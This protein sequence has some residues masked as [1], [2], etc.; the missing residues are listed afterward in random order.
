MDDA[1]LSLQQQKVANSEVAKKNVSVVGDEAAN[2][3]VIHEQR[4]AARYQPPP[5]RRLSA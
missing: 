1:E 5:S 3:A 2:S 4:A